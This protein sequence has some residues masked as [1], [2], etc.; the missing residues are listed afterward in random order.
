VP[1]DLVDSIDTQPCGCIGHQFTDQ[2]LSWTAEFS[3]GRDLQCPSPIDDF[4][5][6]A[7]WLIGK[8][9]RVANQHLKKDRP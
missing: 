4:L 6:S 1:L 3:L 9:G 2:V 7:G 5:A 8:E